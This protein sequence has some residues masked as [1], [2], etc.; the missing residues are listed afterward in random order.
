M[1]EKK[2]SNNMIY[3]YLGR[4]GLKVSVLSN[5]NYVNSHSKESRQFTI[6][7]MQRCIDAG[8]NFFD[9]AEGYGNGTAEVMMGEA[10]RAI[11]VK[12]EDVIISTKIYFLGAGRKGIND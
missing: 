7:S 12:R 2:T 11:G 4:S 5:G 10:I 8:M 6:D 3:R 1:E 9:T